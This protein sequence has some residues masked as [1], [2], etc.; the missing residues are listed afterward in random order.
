[1]TEWHLTLHNSSQVASYKDIHFK[2]HYYGQSGTEID[3]SILGHTEYIIIAPGQSV[4]IKFQEFAHSQ[5]T[6]ATIEVA[7]AKVVE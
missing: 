2:T 1:M 5:T 7:D 6:S 4:P 3:R